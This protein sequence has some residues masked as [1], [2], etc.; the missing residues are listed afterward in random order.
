MVEKLKSRTTETSPRTA[1]GKPNQESPWC[2]ASSGTIKETTPTVSS[3]VTAMAASHNHHSRRSAR[4]RLFHALS[5]DGTVKSFLSSD[6]RTFF[7]TAD[8]RQLDR[9]SMQRK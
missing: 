8:G 1:G 7:F 5:A 2:S 6:G 3:S 9:H 4:R